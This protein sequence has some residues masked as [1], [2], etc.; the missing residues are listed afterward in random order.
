MNKINNHR[1]IVKAMSIKWRWT[2]PLL[3]IQFSGTWR[4]PISQNKFVCI[5]NRKL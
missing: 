3:P 2:L 5:Q 1:C 4:W